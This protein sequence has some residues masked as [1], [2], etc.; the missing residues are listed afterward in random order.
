M[1]VVVHHAGNAGRARE[2]V[3]AITADGG[4]A[5]AAQADVADEAQVAALFD[6]AEQR[7]DGV[8]VVVD[9]AGIMLLSPPTDLSMDDSDRMRRP[10]V[11]GTFV[12]GQQAARRLRRG[13]AL[14]D[15]SRSVGHIALPSCSAYAA[16]RGVDATTLILAQELRGR[17][18]TVD[19]VAPGPT[20]PPLYLD[21]ELREAVDRL[22]SMAPLERP[23]TPRTSPRS[24]PSSLA[25]RWVN[26]QVLYADGG[27]G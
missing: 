19:P 1:T 22:A 7:Y 17:D 20:A 6:T 5:T 25:R 12:V 2:V 11:G 9:T 18:V 3:D 10:N 8:D 21:G 23:G 4:T 27:V 13:G 26:G 15:S 24:W 16:T 14:V